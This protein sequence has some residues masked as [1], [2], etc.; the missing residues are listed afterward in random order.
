MANTAQP[1]GD[2]THTL[3]R[4]VG[5]PRTP[6]DGSGRRA[7][8]PVTVRLLRWGGLTGSCLLLESKALPA[9]PLTG[10]PP[11][12]PPP[13]M[14]TPSSCRSHQVGG[15]PRRRSPRSPPTGRKQSC[16]RCPTWQR[17]GLSRSSSL[18][19]I[20]ARSLSRRVV[21]PRTPSRGPTRALH[22]P[23]AHP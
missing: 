8:S 15:Q 13:S 7:G 10:V 2:S 1:W 18:Q 9:L 4:T 16:H 11:L 19:S 21:R 3:W 14:S 17:N 6:P 22:P 12:S 5:R 23:P 20:P